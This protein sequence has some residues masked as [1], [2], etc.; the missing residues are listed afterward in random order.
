MLKWLLYFW[1]YFLLFLTRLDA[2]KNT[3]IKRTACTCPDAWC[4]TLSITFS[5]LLLKWCYLLQMTLTE[6]LCLFMRGGFI[7]L[8]VLTIW[9][10]RV[11]GF[12]YSSRLIGHEKGHFLWVFYRLKNYNIL[13]YCQ[14]SEKMIL[15]HIS[16]LLIFGPK[17]PDEAYW[18]LRNIIF[19]LFLRVMELF[20]CSPCPTASMQ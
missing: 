1:C 20:W 17:I 6:T 5:H 13:F 3:K 8:S 14:F 4:A 9:N 12:T 15:E 19:R 7:W 10:R 2:L 16:V 18:K 11:L